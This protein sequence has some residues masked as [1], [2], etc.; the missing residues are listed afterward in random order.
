MLSASD[1]FD[2]ATCTAASLRP[3]DYVSNSLRNLAPDVANSASVFIQNA[4]AE[5]NNSNALALFEYA[6]KLQGDNFTNISAL[7]HIVSIFDVEHLKDPSIKM[8]SIIEANINFG[9]LYNSG[10]IDG[11]DGTPLKLNVGADNVIYRQATNGMLLGESDK[12]SF[13]TDDYESDTIQE[14]TFGEKCSVLDTWHT[15]NVALSKDYSF[16]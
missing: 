10:A 15:V 14:M 8:R 4:I 9:N 2:A 13:Y 12:V 7:G 1:M 5:S 6:R 3:F 11:Y 16:T